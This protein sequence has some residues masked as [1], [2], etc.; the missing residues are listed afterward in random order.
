[1]LVGIINP[2]KVRVYDYIKNE[3]FR[4]VTLGIALAF[5]YIRNPHNAFASHK[6]SSGSSITSRNIH[7]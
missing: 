4:P 7:I 1:M 6:T 3:Y 5:I 2:K